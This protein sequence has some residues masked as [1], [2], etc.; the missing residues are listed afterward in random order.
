MFVRTCWCFFLLAALA[1]GNIFGQEP[2]GMRRVRFVPQWTAQAQFAGFYMALEKGF[3]AR[4]NLD[5]EILPGSSHAYATSTLLAGQCD[6]ITGFSPDMIRLRAEGKPVGNIAQ[7]SRIPALLLVARKEANMLAPVD[8]DGR[9]VSVWPS[10]DVQA[11][12]LFRRFDVAPKILAQR[13]SLNL[14]FM[15]VVDACTVMEYNEYHTIINAGLNPNELVVFRYE[16]LGIHFPEDGIYCLD[17]LRHSSP[18][19]CRAFVK[20]TIE[21]WRYAFEHPEEALDVVLR[22]A[23]AEN[24]T[25]TRAHQRWMLN[26]IKRHIVPNGDYENIGFLALSDFLFVR[27]ELLDQGIIAE[28]PEYEDFHENMAK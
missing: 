23:A 22:W 15:G 8:L 20:G 4:R 17:S 10:F 2:A 11:K 7:I 13:N 1:G 25:T 12:A 27:S 19:V 28:L 24:V 9:S 26:S 16:D 3:Y 5:V 14:F 21:G 6:F 18:E